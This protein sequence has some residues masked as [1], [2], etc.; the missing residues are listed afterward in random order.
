MLKRLQGF[1]LSAKNARVR[2]RQGDSRRGFPN[3]RQA[4]LSMAT[5]PVLAVSALAGGVAIPANAA[6]SYTATTPNPGLAAGCG[7]DFTLVLDTSGSIDGPGMI[8]LKK[9]ADAFVDSLVDT[10]SK[11]SISS[12]ATIGSVLLPATALTGTNLTDI[13]ASYNS[14]TAEGFTN[15]EDGLLKAQDTF[16]G[17][18]AGHPD[19]V[20]MITDGIPSTINK[21]GGGTVSVPT[22]PTY[23]AANAAISLTNGF[24]TDHGIQVF[25]IGVGSGIDTNMINRLTTFPDPVMFNGSNFPTADYIMTEDYSQ[26]EAD[27]RAVATQLC[28][29]TVTIHKQIDTDGTVT[30]GGGWAFGASSTATEEGVSITPA[31]SMTGADGTTDPFKVGG[32]ATPDQTFPATFT[33]EP[34]AGYSLES[35]SCQKDGV[36]LPVTATANGF[37][38]PAV[39]ANDILTCTVVNKVVPQYTLTVDKIWIDSIANDNAEISLTPGSHSGTAISAGGNNTNLTVTSGQ[40]GAGDQVTLAETPG[41]RN[42]GEYSTALV[43]DGGSVTGNEL[44]M[45]AADVSCTYTNTAATGEVTLTKAWEHGVAGDKATLAITVPGTPGATFASEATGGNQTDS[46]GAIATVVTGST[47]TIGEEIDPSLGAYTSSYACTHHNEP[48]E[49]SDKEF[50]MPAG[51]VECVVTNTAKMA[52]VTLA[53]TWVNGVMGDTAG[54]SINGSTPEADSTSTATGGNQ[55]DTTHKSTA[56]VSTG[57]T[58]SLS[59]QLA[60]DGDYTAAYTCTSGETDV[61]VSETHTFQMP[62]SGDVDCVVTNTAA[63]APPVPPAKAPVTSVPS[64]M[65]QTGADILGPLSLGGILLVL[66]AGMVFWMMR[67][68]GLHR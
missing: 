41:G 14:L 17:F 55:I 7:L 13:K 3:R 59:E 16:S 39:G 32:F 25:G 46:S 15:W 8:N 53:K 68:R 30:D 40:Y 6:D 48:V 22:I 24:K 45:P 31:S 19:L 12:Y 54:L 38:I 4:W 61:P 60:G 1:G 63:E 9:A 26:L 52:D 67:R 33:E 34:Q 11:L 44:T 66:G 29:G 28:G 20:V 62:S 21:S 18:D 10:G 56:R 5:A 58:V 42:D 57:S 64:G 35:A 47:V 37:T 23:V 43:C 27:L 65:A 2:T 50:V 51:D 36:N 49:L